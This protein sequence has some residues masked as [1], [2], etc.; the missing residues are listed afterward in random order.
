MSTARVSVNVHLDDDTP[1]T[2]HELEVSRRHTT[3]VLDFGPVAVFVDS[4]AQAE[5]LFD[6]VSEL[7]MRWRE[8]KPEVATID[9]VLAPG[10]ID[11][12]TGRRVERVTGSIDEPV[13]IL[14]A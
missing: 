3:I 13:V 10:D 8:L 1:I 6:A 2:H 7:T 9:A 12:E 5:N 11:P 4:R 14:E